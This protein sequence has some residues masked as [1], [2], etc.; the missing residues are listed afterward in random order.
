MSTDFIMK[1]KIDF[2][3]KEL[4]SDKKVRQGFISALLH[5]SPEEVADT[6]LLPTTL[7]G[8]LP[9]DKLGILDVLICLKDGTQIDLEMQVVYFG[10]WPERTLFYLGKMLT[11]QLQKGDP[12]SQIKKC[13]HVGILDFTLF[14][15]EKKYYSQFHI[16]EDNHHMKY[17]DKLEL[18]VLELPKLKQYSSP[19]DELLRWARFFAAESKEEFK[20][21]AK[22]DEYLEAAYDELIKLSADERKYLE[23]ETR[24]KAIRD[25][26]TLMEFGKSEGLRQ[27]LQEG[28][29]Q[30]RQEGLQ[31]GLQEGL[32]QG[33]QEGL[34][35]GLQQARHE[36]ILMFLQELGEIPDELRTQILQT[37]DSE[38]LLKWIKLAA[39]AD[40][41]CSFREQM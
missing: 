30:G 20:M 10:S 28:L 35:Q 4:M 1:P 36:S 32:Q 13:I 25:H 21:A 24:M 8:E 18:H 27:G 22:G 19:G 40:S 15:D 5:I 11:K 41:I 26:N 38:L 34:Q 17:S 39:K 29:L 23:Y 33:H 6:D 2:C 3:F 7:S 12:Y 37:E 16:W 9:D 31:Q 14:P